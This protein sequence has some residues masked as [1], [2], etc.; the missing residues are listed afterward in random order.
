M[1]ILSPDCDLEQDFNSRF[2]D[3]RDNVNPDPVAREI[4]EPHRLPYVLLCDVYERDQIRPRFTGM[5]DV[6]RR[7]E[8]NQDERYHHFAEAPLSG[9][10]PPV[11]LPG[12][13]LDF[14]ILTL[15]TQRLYEAIGAGVKREAVVPPI[16]LHDLVHRFYSFHSRVGI[17]D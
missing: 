10:D 2:H 5:K 14:K 6:W 3:E 15:A 8:K 9:T 1:V 7:L 11:M 12:F 4:E 13:Y 16:Y 17:P